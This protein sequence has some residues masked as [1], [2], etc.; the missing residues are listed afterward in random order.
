ISSH[1]AQISVILCDPLCKN[2]F[3]KRK[4][5]LRIPKGKHAIFKATIKEPYCPNPT[6]STLDESLKKKI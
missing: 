6:N 2:K 1:I 4:T 3:Y 5:I